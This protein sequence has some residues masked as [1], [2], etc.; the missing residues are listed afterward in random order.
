[1]RVRDVWIDGEW[2]HRIWTILP[3]HIHQEILAQCPFLC[4]SAVDN[5]I[6]TGSMNGIYTAR[7]AYHWLVEKDLPPLLDQ[8]WSWIWR[9]EAPENI[10]FLVWLIHHDSLPTKYFLASRRIPITPTC[11]RCV[12]GK[13]TTLH[14]LRDCPD[15]RKIWDYLGLSVS[16]NFYLLN[17]VKE[18]VQ[19]NYHHSNGLFVAALWSVW[20][21][22]NR[23]I[24]NQDDLNV[25]DV[26]Q[27]IQH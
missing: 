26:A 3:P 12:N 16:P 2:H 24:F 10:R 23:K 20:H 19:H 4:D 14:C 17:D 27:H 7:S 11:P 22:R 13:E 21:A 8:Y 25:R 18:W 9:L 6:W 1:M 5:T 15:S